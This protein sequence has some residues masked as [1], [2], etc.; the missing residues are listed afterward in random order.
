[1]IAKLS[2]FCA[3]M[4]VAASCCAQQSA[5]PSDSVNVEDW[6]QSSTTTTHAESDQSVL[7]NGINSPSAKAPTAADVARLLQQLETKPPSAANKGTLKK[8]SSMNG[9]ASAAGSG[10]TFVPGVGYVAPSEAASILPSNVSPNPPVP[11]NAAIG[12]EGAGDQLPAK[13]ASSVKPKGLRAAAAATS[14]ANPGLGAATAGAGTPSASENG[15]G[16][17]QTMLPNFATDGLS[18]N[19]VGTMRNRLD[20]DL[21]LPGFTSATDHPGQRL[22]QVLGAMKNSATTLPA[23]AMGISPGCGA[24][25]LIGQARPSTASSSDCGGNFGYTQKLAFGVQYGEE[26]EDAEQQIE[27]DL[28]KHRCNEEKHKLKEGADVADVNGRDLRQLLPDCSKQ[29][30]QRAENELEGETTKKK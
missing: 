14:A 28:R 9:D 30:Q 6:Q 10:M 5:S 20:L 11:T 12:N 27:N 15:P 29:D 23:G 22:I 18:L 4:L 2:A 13:L 21:S 16:L 7:S 24:S 19:T 26:Q 25:S 8:S 17:G 3:V 1:M